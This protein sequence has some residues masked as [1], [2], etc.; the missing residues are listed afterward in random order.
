ETVQYKSVQ[1]PP[2]PAFSWT[3]FYIGLHVG[4]GWG[5]GDTTF[6]PLPSAASFINL[7]PTTLTPKPSGVLGGAQLGYNYQ[8]GPVVFGFETDFSG[9]GMHE[10]VT[11]SP[12]IQNDGTAFPGAGFLTAR[13]EINWFGTVRGR[14]G[15]TPFQR[16]LIYG[17]GGFAYG[18]I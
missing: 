11:T 4:Y 7:A 2:P 16:L 15:F 13:Q 18:S 3:G 8:M 5:D 17:T 9:T 14:I 1:T 6:Q 10:R 12:I